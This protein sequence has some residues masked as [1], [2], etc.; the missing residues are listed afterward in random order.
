MSQF[1]A[2]SVE[3]NGDTWGPT[4][5]ESLP[6]QFNLLP[7][8]PFA[9]SDR[10]GKCADFTTSASWQKAYNRRRADESSSNADLSYK[11]DADEEDTFQVRECWSEGRL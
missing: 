4:P 8:A 11:V 5:T 3:I 6:A 1:A 9:K 10:L 7:F 2:P